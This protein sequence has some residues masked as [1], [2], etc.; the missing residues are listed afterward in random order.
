MEADKSMPEES[1]IIW[2]KDSKFLIGCILLISSFFLGF[3]GK[4]LFFV[5]FY[6]PVSRYT[7]LSLWALS[8]ILTLIG[9]FLLGMETMKMIRQRIQSQVKKTVRDTYEITKGLPRKGLKYT[10]TL[11]SKGADRMAKV[12]KIIGSKIKH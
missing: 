3:F 1:Q 10:R 12:T 11:H 7:G 4:G 9:I 2:G 6:E 5:K 8:W